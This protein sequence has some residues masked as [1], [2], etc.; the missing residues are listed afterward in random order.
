MQVRKTIKFKIG[1]LN[2]GKQ[3]LI[4]LALNNSLNAIKDFI[5]LSIK[6]K[7]TSSIKL[8][9]L[10]YK[11]TVSKYNLPACIVH[12]SRNKARE[13]VRSWKTNKYRLHKNIPIPEPRALGI[14]YDN[15]TFKI[16][17]TK[18]KEYQYWASILIKKGKK[19]KSDNRIYIP[20]IV[21]SDYQ[22]EYL[23]NLLNKKY[24][25]G[26]ADLVK[27]GDD[28][29]VHIILKKEIEFE[30]KE[31]YNPIGIDIGITNLAVININGKSK[32]FNGKRAIAKKKHLNK[33]KSIYQGRNNLK[34]LNAIKGKEQ[35]Y[36][37]HINHEI[38]SWIIDNAK[39]ID[40]PIIVMEDLSYILETT[41]VRKKQ[42][43]Y[44]QTWAFKKL[45]LMIQYKALWDNI[46]I[47]YVNP[48]YTSQICPK[49][50][51]TNKR[52]KSN[53]KCK[54]CGYKANAD[55]VGAVNITK[56]FLEAICFKETAP[57]NRA[58]GFSISEPQAMINEE[59][60]KSA[61]MEVCNP[62]QS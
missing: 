53:Y 48:Q 50:L 21:N 43:Y 23:N 46:P 47:V 41:K 45:Q 24:K 13:I 4:D 8:H 29:F 9:H 14:R 28:Y 40:N 18:N 6:N 3:E 34:M 19:G 36:F 49:C 42:R 60:K 38:S 39:K 44:H 33:I 11:I 20:L 15:I 30:N 1:E 16:I 26:S 57:I 59:A 12:Q 52:I 27:K 31:N 56:K 55:H 2:K 54:Y 7:T 51:S 35:R 37:N 10:G 25:Q 17:K 5:D 22:K 62:S 58:V 32:F 61:I